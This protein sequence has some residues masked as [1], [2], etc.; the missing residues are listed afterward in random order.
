MPIPQSTLSTTVK[1]TTTTVSNTTTLSGEYGLPYARS[2]P[3]VIE[4]IGMKPFTTLH[5][6]NDNHL[7]D[8][9]IYP[10]AQITITGEVGTFL[11]YEDV[12]PT[13]TLNALRSLVSYDYQPYIN[14][15]YP[16]GFWS[17][18][19]TLSKGETIRY[20]VTP[21]HFIAALVIAR[22]IQINPITKVKE[23]V[24]HVAIMRDYYT[25][26]AYTDNFSTYSTNGIWNTTP[27]PIGSTI[28]GDTS[29]ST[30]VVS[31]VTVP[32]IGKIGTNSLGNF[33]GVY[34][35]PFGG[36]RTGQHAITFSD[37]ITNDSSALTTCETDFVSKGILDVYTNKIVQRTDTFVTNTYK[38]VVIYDD[39][40]A[41]TFIIPSSNID[42]VYATSV[43]LY[44]AS[45]AATETQPVIVQI[46]ETVNGYPTPK[47]LFN[48]IASMSPD[49]IFTSTDASIATRFK[50]KGPVYLQPGIEYCVKVLSNSTGYKLYVAQMG[51][52]NIKDPTKL[53]SQQPYLGSFFQSQNNSTWTSN[54][55]MDLTFQ[56]NCAYFNTST[57]GLFTVQNQS[58][59]TALS[60]LP[61]NPFQVANGQT[62]VKVNYPNH[63]LPVG[64]QVT[65]SGSTAT[66][67]NGNF[68]VNK[69]INSDFFTIVVSTPQTFNGLTGGNVVSATKNIRYD[70]FKLDIG[71]DFSIKNGTNISTTV[72][73]SSAS[74]KDVTSI[75]VDRN[76]EYVL[77]N[78]SRYIHSD[79]NENLF[80]GGKK[81]IDVNYTM[82]STTPYLSPV[83]DRNTI[84]LIVVEN[85][86]NKPLQSD[87]VS[88]DNHTIFT[89]QSGVIFNVTTN[90]IGIPTSVD[91]TQ[92]NIGAYITI[93]GTTSNNMT[94]QIISV[95][96]TTT[97]YSVGVTGTL[98][99]ETPTATTIVQANGY[100]SEIAPTGGT[101]ES[102]YQTTAI[103]LATPA[104][105]L[106]I[107]FS[108]V[109]PPASD[110]HVYYRVLNGSSNT[111]ITDRVW[112][113]VTMNYTKSQDNHFVEQQYTINA[114]SN[115]NIAQFKI[116]MTT[117]DT[118][119]VPKISD[120]RAICLA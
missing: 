118:T 96:N 24:L 33:F 72:I 94:T 109:I 19:F 100:I 14:A 91:L 101:A 92:F 35:I 17:N 40:I 104:T 51:E 6:F 88:V 15:T 69:V 106:Q 23:T 84:G 48:A 65:F 119:Q 54:Q 86:I 5:A 45:K 37:S 61:A 77:T 89:N 111:K 34:I 39:P 114:L 63:G 60:K 110:I 49:K 58:N 56:L 21:T 95:D 26:S 68:A 8:A 76:S 28:T 16:F 1:K 107:M 9:N 20:Y 44:F 38:T 46:C 98:V 25:T 31:A 36:V 102:K 12:S 115:F 74:N 2:I 80:L 53:I 22:Q 82:T 47:I 103:A 93:S 66:I 83:L 4:A 90:I 50:F 52:A 79:L 43:D 57:E 11:G 112:V 41:E 73:M 42:G 27:F 67:F 70:S 117:T 59:V 105:G 13:N 7:I 97:P 64:G 71:N 81:S 30:G 78:G 75:S 18:S 62:L 87:S 29:H 3:I 120:F 55:L 108:A 113:P 116:V 32:T 99:A 10:C 85:K